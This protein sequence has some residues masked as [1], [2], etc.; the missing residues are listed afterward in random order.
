[1]RKPILHSC[2]QANYSSDLFL[3]GVYDVAREKDSLMQF[4]SGRKNMNFSMIENK[5]RS[6]DRATFEDM[7]AT[8]TSRRVPE[9]EK[10][11][12]N[13]KHT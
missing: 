10:G 4:A 7:P 12:S 2:K 3:F 6:K 9:D 5:T 1:M 11:W 8:D 13:A